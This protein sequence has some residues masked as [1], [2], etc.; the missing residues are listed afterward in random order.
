MPDP[1]LSVLIPTYRRPRELGEAIRS[2]LSNG[3]TAGPLEVVVT[4]D[5]P[6][7]GAAEAVA[8]VG[9]ERVR[10]LVHAAGPEKPRNWQHGAEATRGRYVFKLDDDDIIRPGFLAKTVAL[11][12]SHV[13]VG[14]VY[15]AYEH[16]DA[17]TG[18]GE[19]IID[20]EFF[21]DG[22]VPGHHY[23]RA[24][25]VNEGGF[26]RNQKT[27]AVFRRDVAERMGF[28]RH[29]SDDFSFSAALGV[30][31]DVAYIPEPLYVWHRHGAN[32]SADLHKV[33]RIAS[34]SLDGLERLPTVPGQPELAREWP[35]LIDRCRQALPIYYLQASLRLHGAAATW[36]LWQRFRAEGAVRDSRRG[37]V[38]VLPGM[39]L[40][41]AAHRAVMAAYMRSPRMQALARRLFT[42]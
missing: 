29:A 14:S 38:V 37:W 41:R 32:A 26:P 13:N 28:Y 4:D 31:A 35:A 39:L 10:H 9:D 36:R 18:E 7:G 20:R 12:E 3:F 8:A 21:A 23:L 30:E 22:I 19:T 34:E 2:V 17:A 11:L 6:K 5:D 40:P 24:V 33:W 15:T 42:R 16:R 25:L 1:L 27:T